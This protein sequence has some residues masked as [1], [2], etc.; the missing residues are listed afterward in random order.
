MEHGR[1][2]ENTRWE[3]SHSP[4]LGIFRLSGQFSLLFSFFPQIFLA[5]FGPR[6]L[7]NIL[8]MPYYEG[9]EKEGGTNI[10]ET[11]KL[12]KTSA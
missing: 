2:W 9:M 3:F 4:F 11:K 10:F 5:A 6:K 8:F 7:A 1:N 12:R